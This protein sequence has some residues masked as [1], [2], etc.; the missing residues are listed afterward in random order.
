MGLHHAFLWLFFSVVE[1]QSTNKNC[2]QLRCMTW[3]VNTHTPCDVI[4]MMKLTSP[5][6]HTV[7]WVF[8][9]TALKTFPFSKFQVDNILVR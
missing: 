6:P 8:V 3:C 9:V 7:C 1:V 4:T 2:T 5:S